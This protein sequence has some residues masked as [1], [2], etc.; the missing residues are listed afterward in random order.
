MDDH[1]E[2]EFVFVTLEEC[3]PEAANMNPSDAAGD[4][5][6]LVPPRTA[7]PPPPPPPAV[8]LPHFGEVSET[9]MNALLS[10]KRGDEDSNTCDI[11]ET[12]QEEEEEAVGPDLEALCEDFENHDERDDSLDPLALDSAAL[13]NKMDIYVVD[14]WCGANTKMDVLGNRPRSRRHDGKSCS[15]FS[16]SRNALDT[17]L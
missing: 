17:Y 6:M 16:Y 14:K 2:D 8:T 15:M 11:A 13:H 5:W 1:D 3:S 10:D 4:W 7:S 9:H 12:Q